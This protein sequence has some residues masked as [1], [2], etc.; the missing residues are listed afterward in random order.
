[1]AKRKTGLRSYQL[2]AHS[3]LPWFVTSPSLELWNPVWAQSPQTGKSKTMN[4]ADLSFGWIWE[5]QWQPK[6]PKRG[7]T[8][9]S[10]W[11]IPVLLWFVKSSLGPNCKT[12]KNKNRNFANSSFG[13]IWGIQFQPKCQKR[14]GAKNSTLQIPVL[15]WLVKSGVCPNGPKLEKQKTWFCESRCC[16]V[17]GNPMSAKMAKR[18]RDKKVNLASSSSALIW[19]IQ[20]GPKCPNGGEGKKANSPDL[21]VDLLGDIQ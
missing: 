13:L 8:K 1:M 16:L 17:S 14:G 9:K 5:I 10:T 11:Q 3:G 2:P 12:G 20:F 19:E 7:R 18:G 4:F 15:P 6:S 21:R